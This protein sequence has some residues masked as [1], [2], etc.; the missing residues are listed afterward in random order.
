MSMS[1]REIIAHADRGTAAK[2]G[3]YAMIDV[4]PMGG[5]FVVQC[6]GDSVGHECP[7]ADDVLIEPG[8]TWLK[9][10]DAIAFAQRHIE[11]HETRAS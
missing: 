3:V 1:R 2:L 4:H 7:G 8:D 5:C 9:L 11:R 10:S 6:N